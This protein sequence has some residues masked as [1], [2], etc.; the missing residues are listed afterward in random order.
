MEIDASCY[1]IKNKKTQQRKYNDRN[2]GIKPVKISTVY[3]QRNVITVLPPKITH[4][5]YE[6]RSQVLTPK[7]AATKQQEDELLTTNYVYFSKISE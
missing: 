4:H 6:P 2:Y 1:K 5:A 3:N 7:V